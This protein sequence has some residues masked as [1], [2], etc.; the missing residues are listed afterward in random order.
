[1]QSILEFL[2]PVSSAL[3]GL[4]L[5]THA[6]DLYFCSQ[7]LPLAIHCKSIKSPVHQ[8]QGTGA[9]D[10]CFLQGHSW[11]ESSSLF[12][13]TPSPCSSSNQPAPRSSPIR[14]QGKST[15]CRKKRCRRGAMGALRLGRQ[16]S[17]PGTQ[18]QATQLHA[19]GVMPPVSAV[20]VS[21]TCHTSTRQCSGGCHFSILGADTH[22][23]Q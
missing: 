12:L 15:P 22:I 10:T 21:S 17:R 9:L 5:I 6:L 13:T 7:T 16:P 20:A 18:R 23:P 1:M 4:A 14:K 2:A 11:S 8:Q 19:R 3:K